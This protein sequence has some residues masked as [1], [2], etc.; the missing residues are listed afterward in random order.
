MPS[1]L[2]ASIGAV[3]VGTAGV[4]ATV[5]AG[6]CNFCPGLI[7]VGSTP[8]FAAAIA[9]ALTWKLRPMV[10]KLSPAFITYSVAPAAPE[11]TAVAGAEFDAAPAVAHIAFVSA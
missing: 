9:L 3:P 10:V 2:A 11:S 7:F 1:D 5:G 4:A 8:G 6:I